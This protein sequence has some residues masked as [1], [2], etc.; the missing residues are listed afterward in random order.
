MLIPVGRAADLKK[1]GWNDINTEERFCQFDDGYYDLE[2]AFQGTG[3]FQFAMNKID[4][5]KDHV[6]DPTLFPCS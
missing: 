4:G 1:W 5:G 6:L 2:E 3:A